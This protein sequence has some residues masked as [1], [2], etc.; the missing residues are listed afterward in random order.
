MKRK[1]LVGLVALLLAAASSVGLYQ[2][3]AGAEEKVETS[4][5]PNVVIDASDYPQL[6]AQQLVQLSQADES[7][8]VTAV[9]F[10]DEAAMRDLQPGIYT[11]NVAIQIS[12]NQEI[13]RTV[14]INVWDKQGPD[15]T[16]PKTVTVTT[17]AEFP[18]EKYSVSDAVDGKIASEDLSV[19]GYDANKLGQQRVTLAATDQAGNKTT[20]HVSVKVLAAEADTSL[21]AA[22]EENDASESPETSEAATA[23]S[24]E[25]VASTRATT[26]EATTT[27]SEDEATTTVTEA[28]STSQS[29][30]K[31]EVETEATTETTTETATAV[32]TNEETETT[33]SANEEASVAIETS[34][35]KFAGVTVPFGQSNGASAA[36]GSGAGTWMGSGSVSD[37]APTHFIG[38]NPGDFAGVMSLDV[39]S[40]ITVVD[41]SGASRTYTVYEVLDVTDEGYNNR[42]LQ[43]DVL[44]RMLYDGG[45]RISLQT[46]ISDTVNRCV[47]AR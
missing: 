19:T 9:S 8:T 12:F 7:G 41:A 11:A 4:F 13:T 22:N 18:V 29:E 45:E 44:P 14:T 3:Y 47:L 10:S 30:I 21:T 2:L 46:C 6:T 25:T 5:R 26:P 1:Y 23:E 39:G 17:G 43:D 16:V 36:P 20:A 33:A 32:T 42:N 15:I 37:G 28:T 24:N 35:L 31:E 38:H 40:T 27:T 34:V